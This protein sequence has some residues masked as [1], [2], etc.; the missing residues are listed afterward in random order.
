M[1]SHL[2]AFGLGAGLVLLAGGVL[3]IAGPRF[4]E[5]NGDDGDGVR[6]V[7]LEDGDS[8]SFQLKEGKL[9]VAAKWKGDFLFAG[10]ARSLTSLAESLEVE[11]K[12]GDEVRKAVFESQDGK[13]LVTAF[14]NES[15]L[16]GAE[17]DAEAAALL[18]TFARSSSVNADQRLKAIIAQG[19]KAAAIAEIGALKG[20]HA[21]SAYIGALSKVAT[22]DDE[23]VAG[24]SSGI[25]SLASDYAKRQ[26]L[27][28]LLEHQKLGEA[29][30]QSV[31]AAA[32]TIR[33]DHEVRLIIEAL[34]ER[35]M[36]SANA[37][38]ASALLADIESDHE[39]R[40]AVEALIENGSLS[41]ADAARSI[42]AAV[43]A[44]E[45]DY[46]KRLVIE[47]AAARFGDAAI[48]PAAIAAGDGIKS[49]H[50]RRLA[51]ENIAENL[52]VSSPYWTQLIALVK[53]IDSD[54]E[55][56]LAIESL[57]DHA[58][59]AQDV[60]EA[61]AAAAASIGSDHDRRLAQE[62]LD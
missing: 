14:K 12:D 56:R 40:L 36:T 50:E 1:R 44:I 45:G 42:A 43:S 32:K 30:L 48:A 26:A 60:R 17:A 61:L 54:H 28:S 9:A 41:G 58:P 35:E 16:G 55:R 39:I 62:S 33:S 6:V 27:A 47:A 52:A 49:A 24:L 8:G 11:V 15:A 13:I 18:Q 23:D 38:T 22:L 2:T 7:N 46:E 31:L 5:I 29:G 19:G 4:I 37:S 3:A 34:S 59:D 25:A 51:V 10:D 57:A 21:A 20:G 53:D